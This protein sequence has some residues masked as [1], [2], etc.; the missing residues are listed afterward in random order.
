ML[1]RK[2]LASSN[3]TIIYYF[4]N[5]VPGCLSGAWDDA[6]AF[7]Q[8]ENSINAIV[9]A[10]LTSLERV[11]GRDNWNNIKIPVLQ[12]V[13]SYAAGQSKNGW[14]DFDENDY[15]SP[16][17]S[18]TGLVVSGLKQE[19]ETSFTMESSYFNLTCTEPVFFNLSNATINLSGGYVDWGGFA[20]WVGT[21][22]ERGNNSSK[23]FQGPDSTFSSSYMIDTNYVYTPSTVFEPRYNIIYASRNY[24]SDEIAAYNCTVGVFHVENEVTCG[25]DCHI[26]RIRPSHHATWLESGW[27]W[28]CF[29]PVPPS[30]LLG[31]LD[32]F[33][34]QH[35]SA[36][37]SPLDFYIRGFNDPFSHAATER[38][39]NLTYRNVSGLD[40]AKR[41]QSLVN[42]GWQLGFQGPAT[43]K[44]P[45]E[46]ETALM[47][48]ANPETSWYGVGVGYPVTA[49]NAT[50]VKKHDVFASNVIWI[51]ITMIVSFLLLSCGI[52]S[53]MFKY[54][55]NSPDIPGFVSSMTRDNPNFEQ[56]PDGDKFDGL[57]RARVLGHMKVQIV[58]VK[59]WDSDGH[60]TL[61]P[62]NP[63]MT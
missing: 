16:Y 52:V 23:L 14:Y 47:L 18:L 29:S 58:D 33:S 41:L 55:T 27:P 60:V 21:L 35:L 34:G 43:A 63:P 38:E 13:P 44:K 20:T 48:S 32:S 28:P 36:A 6:N 4:N 45:D 37:I 26:R 11:K 22:A 9:Q 15:D 1:S 61:K 40:V 59:P 30:V 3:T 12:Y 56:I 19:V 7:D 8:Y 39:E 25:R 57:K 10:C 46:N 2:S 54:G 62:L 17:S 49:T 5:T 50:T 24:I 31:W 53:M 42:T 51:M